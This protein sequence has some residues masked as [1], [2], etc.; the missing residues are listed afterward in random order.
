M[1]H[2]SILASAVVGFCASAVFAGP[3]MYGGLGGHGP[4]STSTNDGSL[5]TVDQTTG[6]VTVIGH[7]A[8]V[9]R[10][11]GL[12]FDSTGTLFGSTLGS[13][14][15]PPPP[16]KSTSSLIQINP[17]TGAL[18]STIGSITN[19][20]GGPAISIA[21][22]AEQPGTGVLFGIQAPVDG[23]GGQGDLYTI[24]KQTA[25]ATLVGNTG[26]FFGSLAFAPT[27]TLYMTSADPGATGEPTNP[28]LLTLNPTNAQTLSSISTSTFFGALGVRPTDGALFAGNGDGSQIF[29][30]DPATGAAAALSH[31]TGSNLV[32]DVDFRPAT[33]AVPLPPAV[34]TGSLTLLGLFA[35]GTVRKRRTTNAQ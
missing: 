11:T 10:L 14:P 31:A 8:G 28:H 4:G 29:L 32:G 12:A 19:G 18:Q 34:W 6:D 9:A 3:V 2:R 16:V 30:L 22:L 15:F 17:D 7:P 13:I 25:V 35:I 26:H 27:G 33:T 24:N 21:D 5:V 20:V 23:L 1:L